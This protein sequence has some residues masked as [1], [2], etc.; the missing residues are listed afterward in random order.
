M[1]D[2]KSYVI[3]FLTCVCLFLIMGQTKADSQV[4]R[5]QPIS[6]KWQS[7]ALNS[8]THIQLLDTATGGIYVIEDIKEGKK[9]NRTYKFGW[10]PKYGYEESETWLGFISKY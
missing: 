9:K 7:G 5:Y 6:I 3:G 8:G 10:I 2:I 4:G 1:K